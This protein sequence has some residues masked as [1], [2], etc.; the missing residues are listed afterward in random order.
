MFTMFTDRDGKTQ[1]MSLAE[2]ALDPLSRTSR[3]M[4]TEEAHHMFVGRTGIGRIIERTCQLMKEA[5]IGSGGSRRAP[6]RRHRPADDPEARSTC[7][8]R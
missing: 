6:D 1:L 2:I 7:T 4:L 3:F 8:S 5:G